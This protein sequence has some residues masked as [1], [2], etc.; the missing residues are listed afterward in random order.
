MEKQI[1]QNPIQLPIADNQ[2]VN[3]AQPKPNY[4]K[5]IIFSVLIIVTLGLIAYLIFQNQK[6]QKQVLNPQLSPTIQAPSPTPKTSS[7]ISIPP[8]ETANW[9]TYNS[10][11]LDISIK[12]PNNWFLES[13][14]NNDKSFRIQNYDPATAPGRGYSPIDDKGKFFIFFSDYSQIVKADTVN[15]LTLELNKTKR[16]YS[17]GDDIGEKISLNEQTKTINSVTIFSREVQCPKLQP[18][19]EYYLLDGKDKIVMV[20]LGLDTESG[21]KYIDQILSTFKFVG[22]N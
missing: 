17:M 11:L 16:C 5:T 20:S 18:Y 14:N 12:Y 19:K 4:L 21:N 9:K 1:P 8:D 15:K 13:E 22:E 2:S 3:I 10:N 7:S 6:L